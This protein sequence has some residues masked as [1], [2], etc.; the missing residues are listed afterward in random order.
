MMSSRFLPVD[1]QA[2]VAGADDDVQHL[3]DRIVHVHGA[4]PD[5]RH[6]HLVD[7]RLGQLD[8]AVDHLLLVLLDAALLAAGLDQHLQLLGRQVAGLRSLLAAKRAD[9]QPGDQR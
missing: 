5:A 6:H 2:R 3:V 1:R 7:L 4:D 8:D 9:E